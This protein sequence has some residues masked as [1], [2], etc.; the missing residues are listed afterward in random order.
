MP[1]IDVRVGDVVKLRKP[2]PC[3][4]FEWDVMRIGADIG[5]KCRTCGRR[6]MLT[7]SKFNKRMKEF[8]SRARDQHARTL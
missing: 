5:L 3:G 4:S 1:V 2:H 6:V 8:V 7:R